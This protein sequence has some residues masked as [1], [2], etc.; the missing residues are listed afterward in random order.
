MAERPVFIPSL[1]GAALVHTRHVPFQ[2]YPG[3]SAS[4]K[5]KSVDS[6]HASARKHLGLQRILEVSSKSRDHLG[7]SLSAFNLT[8]TTIKH[9]RTFS[10]ECAFQ[11]SKVFENGGPYIDLLEMS[12]REAKKDDRLRSSGRLVGFRFFG[13]DWELQPQTAFYDWLYINAL[14]K[15]PTLTRAL[16]E[17]SAFTDIEFNPERSINCQAY[18]VALY[19]SLNGRGLLDEAILS[20]EAF[21]RIVGSAPIS[22]ARRDETLQRDLH[23]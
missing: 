20:K 19:V 17:F 14:K 2:W 4:Q 6:L 8:F 22:N 5:Q 16:A 21:L 7:V 23:I 18:S 3:L 13:T 12:S 9:Q 1:E 11:G 10:V 15:Q